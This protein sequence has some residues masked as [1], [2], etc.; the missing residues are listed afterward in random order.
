[1]TFLVSLFSALDVGY[2]VAFV[3]VA[4][5]LGVH[6]DQEA[7]ECSGIVQAVK[8]LFDFLGDVPFIARGEGRQVWMRVRCLFIS[9]KVVC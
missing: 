3:D 9:K 5:L 6:L 7:A 4:A 2:H 8:Y 1:M